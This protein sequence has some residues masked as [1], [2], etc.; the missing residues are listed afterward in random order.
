MK[1]SADVLPRPRRFGRNIHTSYF[2]HLVIR[3]E[4]LSLLSLPSSF[5]AGLVCI[6]SDIEVTPLTL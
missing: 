4:G 1:K 3:V 6:R 5:T 2:G